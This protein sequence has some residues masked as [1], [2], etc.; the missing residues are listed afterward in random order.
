MDV[1]TALTFVRQGADQKGGGSGVSNALLEQMA[2][3]RVCLCWDNA[4]FRQVLDERSGYFARQG[5]AGELAARLKQIAENPSE[6]LNRALTGQQLAENYG[7]DAH[8][9]R[10]ERTVAQ[11]I[12][13]AS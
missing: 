12:G 4:A 3:G 6:A 1:C 10:F 8:M 5:D 13:A 11:W 7:L 2:A 9:Q